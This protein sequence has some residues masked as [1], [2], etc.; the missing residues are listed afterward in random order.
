MTVETI[1]IQS[2][3]SSS[4]TMML[5]E[6]GSTK[7]AKSGWE[8]SVSLIF[9]KLYP[10]QASFTAHAVNQSWSCTS[11]SLPQN[12]HFLKYLAWCGEATLQLFAGSIELTSWK[13]GI[14]VTGNEASRFWKC[15]SCLHTEERFDTNIWNKLTILSS[16]HHNVLH[17]RT[18]LLLKTY[19]QTLPDSI[20]ISYSSFCIWRNQ[21]DLLRLIN[22]SWP[23]VGVKPR[24][25][26]SSLLRIPLNP[27]YVCQKWILTWHSLEWYLPRKCPK[28]RRSS[29]IW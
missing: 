2:V 24:T 7:N 1:W 13:Q 18:N 15:F 19:H 12:L 23:I 9:Q 20:I 25:K 21:G 29:W 14:N 11:S 16:A 17:P 28:P 27:F 6:T 3:I 10:T 22:I 5:L 4:H 26:L 8:N